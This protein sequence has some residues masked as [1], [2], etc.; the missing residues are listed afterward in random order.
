MVSLDKTSSIENESWTLNIERLQLA[1][2]NIHIFLFFF[3]SSP[4]LVV[5]S[6]FIFVDFDDF[7][8]DNLYRRQHFMW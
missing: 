3:L 7:G 5:Y 4:L 6:L 2:V 8:F 1:G